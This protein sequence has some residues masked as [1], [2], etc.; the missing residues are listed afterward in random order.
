MNKT[1][2][3][4]DYMIDPETGQPWAEGDPDENSDEVIYG[5]DNDDG[6]G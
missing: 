4:E 3:L 1:E 5:E 6:E 2:I